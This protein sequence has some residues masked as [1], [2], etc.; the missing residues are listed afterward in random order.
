MNGRDYFELVMITNVGNGGAIKSVQI[1][2]T[3]TG[4]MAMSRNW[5]ANWQS[6]SFLNGQTLSFMV[7]TDDGI[8]KTFNNVVPSSWAFGQTFATKVQF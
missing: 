3:K 4:W 8:T 6:N 7:T 1:K 5:G 2:G